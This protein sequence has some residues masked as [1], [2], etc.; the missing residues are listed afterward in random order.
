MP[1][2]AQLAISGTRPGGNLLGEEPQPRLG[3]LELAD[4]DQGA[5]RASGPSLDVTLDRAPRSYPCPG[6]VLPVK[7]VFARPAGGFAADRLSSSLLHPF[8]IV[9]MDALAPPA[10]VAHH[11]VPVVA[12]HRL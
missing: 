2:D 5:N 8:E 6:A 12:E 1:H 10:D 11:L 4:I 9:R 3:L 7:T